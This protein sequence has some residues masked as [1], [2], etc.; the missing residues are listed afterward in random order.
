MQNGNLRVKASTNVSDYTLQ[1]KPFFFW[2][3]WNATSSIPQHFSPKHDAV[4][5]DKPWHFP[6]ETWSPSPCINSGFTSP[7]CSFYFASYISPSNCTLHYSFWGTSVFSANTWTLISLD[8][9][10]WNQ[11]SVWQLSTSCPKTS[12]LLL[13]TLR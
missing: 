1:P 4:P 11:K 13:R 5:S 3:L 12:S 7:N 10:E 2:N 8:I 6:P 9:R